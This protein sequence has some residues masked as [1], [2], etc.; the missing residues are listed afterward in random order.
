[1]IALLPIPLAAPYV[2]A[3]RPDRPPAK[4]SQLHVSLPPDGLDFDVP[5]AMMPPR[6]V[7]DGDVPVGTATGKHVNTGPR[8]RYSGGS[9][10]PDEA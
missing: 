1:M 4:V 3:Y 6:A 2:V 9:I 5:T 8:L 10:L 7:M